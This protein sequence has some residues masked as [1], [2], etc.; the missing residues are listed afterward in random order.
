M[1]RAVSPSVTRRARPPV[2]GPASVTRKRFGRPIASHVAA[3]SAMI[4]AAKAGC[5]IAAVAK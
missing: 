3:A 2:P 5:A 1:P 4:A